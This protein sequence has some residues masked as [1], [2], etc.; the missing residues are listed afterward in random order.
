MW[1]QR[2]L[3]RIYEYETYSV[4]L[5]IDYSFSR[6]DKTICISCNASFVQWR[7]HSQW[8]LS[9]AWL[10]LVENYTQY[11][12]LT[13]WNMGGSRILWTTSEKRQKHECRFETW[14]CITLKKHVLSNEYLK[15][16][17]SSFVKIERFNRYF[18]NTL[19]F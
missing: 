9:E 7:Y 1:N 12:A 14:T 16:T 18:T 2:F 13:P 17:K 15:G 19:D 4:F 11:P 5:Y 6:L 8:G 10:L 3:H